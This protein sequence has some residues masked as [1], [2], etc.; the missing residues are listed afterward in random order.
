MVKTHKSILRAIRPGGSNVSRSTWD[1][2]SLVA[3]FGAGVDVGFEG[4]EE[5]CAFLHPALR[6]RSTGTLEPVACSHIVEPASDLVEVLSDLLGFLERVVLTEAFELDLL[7]KP[8][9]AL[10]DDFG[11]FPCSQPDKDVDELV[12]LMS[13]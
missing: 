4:F 3:T 2:A 7:D 13:R 10:L 6:L 9:F 1:S 11:V 12:V 8:G 5:G